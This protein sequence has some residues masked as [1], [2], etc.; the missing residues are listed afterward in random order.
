MIVHDFHIVGIAVAPNK[1]DA[2]LVVNADAVLS[3]SIAFQRFQVIAW[4]RLQIAKFG[5]DI[6]LPQLSLGHPF[7]SPKAFDSLPAV[8][9][10]GL[11]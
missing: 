8:K 2:P 4:W 1:A 5:G 11:P 6:Q 3:F 7:A 9:V 10:F